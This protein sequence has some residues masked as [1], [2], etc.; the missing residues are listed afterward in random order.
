MRPA[1]ARL[2][3]VRIGDEPSLKPLRGEVR[4]SPSVGYQL[5][6][7]DFEGV[8]MGLSHLYAGAHLWIAFRHE[9]SDIYRIFAGP[10]KLSQQERQQY[11]SCVAGLS[12]TLDAKL[13]KAEQEGKQ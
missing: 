6:A 4:D 7:A 11:D 9:K 8:A 10:L 12:R 3:W 2:I 1:S 13:K 5:Y